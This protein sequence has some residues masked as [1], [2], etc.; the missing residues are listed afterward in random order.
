MHLKCT[1]QF[2][3]FSRI[4]S[5]RKG[6]SGGRP[7]ILY[8]KKQPL[9]QQY[10]TT[11]YFIMINNLKKPAYSTHMHRI[12]AHCTC[13]ARTAVLVACTATLILPCPYVLGQAS[14]YQYES[15]GLRTNQPIIH[16]SFVILKEIISRLTKFCDRPLAINMKGQDSLLM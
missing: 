14:S 13:I 11:I 5:F 7:F 3:V 16:K 12:H 6:L 8:Y 1:L 2:V 9:T 15:I 10:S 4:N